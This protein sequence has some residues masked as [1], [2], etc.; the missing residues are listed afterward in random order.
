MTPATTLRRV[1]IAEDDPNDRRLILRALRKAGLDA[2]L[3]FVDDGQAVLDQLR[4]PEQSA[5]PVVVLLD[6]KMPRLSGLEALKQIRE[7]PA[8]RLLPVVMLTSSREAND[9]R[10]AYS[11]GANG[12][13]VKPTGF[14]QF[15]ESVERTLRFWMFTNEPPAEG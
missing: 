9:L 14:E 8:L 4:Q 1:L 3:D 15:V 12:F 13:V 7:D 6:I 2:G 11:L 10:L 5:R